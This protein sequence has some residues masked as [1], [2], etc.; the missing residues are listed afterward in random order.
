[1]TLSPASTPKHYLKAIAVD[2]PESERDRWFAEEVQT[3]EPLLRAVLR[4]SVS[5]LA[6]IDDLIQ[7]AFMRILKAREKRPIRSTKSFLFA[8]A[9]NAMHDLVR[10]RTVA[11]SV[12]ITETVSLNVLDDRPGVVDLVIRRQEL[13]LLAEAVRSLPARC[14]QVFLLRKI[15][16][17]SQREIARQLSISENTVETLVAKGARRCAD[18]LRSRGVCGDSDHAA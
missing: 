4:R 16:G 13:D 18:Y 6:D 15:Q 2:S 7:E 12:S 8:V 11:D 1:L 10:R 5:S 9:R 14:R 3:H 17:L